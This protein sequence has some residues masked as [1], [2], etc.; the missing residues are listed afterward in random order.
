[1]NVIRAWIRGGQ[2]AAQNEFSVAQTRFENQQFFDILGVFVS[3]PIFLAEFLICGPK[4]NLG[5]PPLVWMI[6]LLI[7]HIH[8]HSKFHRSPGM[9]QNT[10]IGESHIIEQILYQW[11]RLLGILHNDPEQIRNQQKYVRYSSQLGHFNI[12][13]I[14]WSYAI[15]D[16]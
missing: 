2:P 10:S 15:N 1:M 5:W 16:R 7:T 12:S 13:K 9:Q 6:N 14:C 8:S 11:I 4:I 3:M